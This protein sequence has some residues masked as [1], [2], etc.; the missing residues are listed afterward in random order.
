MK[1]TAIGIILT[2]ALVLV[3]C[4]SSE[5]VISGDVENVV[6]ENAQEEEGG[7]QDLPEKKQEEEESDGN[8]G[9]VFEVKDIAIEIDA[10]A[11]G[12]IEAL[13]EPL[14]YYEA[15]S[16]AFGDLDKIYTYNGFEMDTYSLEGKDYVSAIIF[17]DDSIT[18]PEGICIGEAAEK[19][20]EVYGE[21]TEEKDGTAVY[22]KGGMKLNF[23]I[24]DDKVVSIEYLST[25]L[26]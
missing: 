19:V 26:E 24:Q 5:N 3:G 14:S 9:Y 13:G 6:T 21:P 10:E 2:A 7:S 12:Y 23:L 1:K 18:T 11:E 22:G 25:V 16:C 17:K 15:P 8:K 20:K 4:G